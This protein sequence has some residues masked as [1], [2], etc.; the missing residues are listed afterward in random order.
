MP[1]T[2]KSNIVPILKENID[3]I[4]LVVSY[5][6]VPLTVDCVIFGFD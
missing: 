2:L 6:T 5:P 4:Q 3:A 1:E